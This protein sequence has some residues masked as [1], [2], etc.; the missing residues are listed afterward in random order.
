MRSTLRS[1]AEMGE[2]ESQGFNGTHCWDKEWGDGLK[3]KVSDTMV[4]LR[5]F[6]RNSRRASFEKVEEKKEWDE[7]SAVSSIYSSDALDK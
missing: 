6:R 3:G 7:S 5:L 2:A 4:L 1:M